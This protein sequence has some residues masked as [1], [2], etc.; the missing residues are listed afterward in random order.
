MP[1]NSEE[2]GA[3]KT[4]NINQ[5]VHQAVSKPNIFILNQ[6]IIILTHTE[7]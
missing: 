4:Q 5:T 2:R 3:Q 6:K 1:L 7:K